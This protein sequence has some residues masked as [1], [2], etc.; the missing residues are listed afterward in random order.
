MP[1]LVC[2]CLLTFLT[3]FQPCCL[4]PGQHLF[5][6]VGHASEFGIS[7]DFMGMPPLS[8][9]HVSR[10]LRLRGVCSSVSGSVSESPPPPCPP[11]HQVFK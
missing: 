11:T 9:H 5:V 6:H 8:F 7:W 2:L 10:G 1:F 4:A 3:L